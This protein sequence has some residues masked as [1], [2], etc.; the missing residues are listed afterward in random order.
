M[1]VGD[2]LDLLRVGASRLNPWCALNVQIAWRVCAKWVWMEC[3]R[4]EVST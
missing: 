3:V 2:R 4:V 1:T